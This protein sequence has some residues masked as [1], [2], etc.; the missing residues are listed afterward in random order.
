MIQSVVDRKGR[1]ACIGVLLTDKKGSQHLRA[2][3]AREQEDGTGGRYS[4]DVGRLRQLPLSTYTT[5]GYTSSG[6][7]DT[8]LGKLMR[9]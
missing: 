5:W 8:S 7:S 1:V 4:I 3:A 6:S 9:S 2:D